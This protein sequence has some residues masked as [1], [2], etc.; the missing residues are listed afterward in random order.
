M[1]NYYAGILTEDEIAKHTCADKRIH[2]DLSNISE[3]DNEEYLKFMTW[4]IYESSATNMPWRYTGMCY[5]LLLYDTDSELFRENFPAALRKIYGAA[6]RDIFY[7]DF[8]DLEW[9]MNIIAPD[10]RIHF[11]EYACGSPCDEIRK[12]AEEFLNES[13]IPDTE[14]PYYKYTM[15][16]YADFRRRLGII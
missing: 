7:E 14:A 12:D 9:F 6:D 11:L 1:D 4:V 10:L 3:L 2:S 15:A 13:A 8:Y 5:T 16:E